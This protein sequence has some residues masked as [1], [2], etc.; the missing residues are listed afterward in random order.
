MR[1]VDSTMGVFVALQLGISFVG[2]VAPWNITGEAT[3]R[4]AV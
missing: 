3:Q 2:T 1:R 4:I